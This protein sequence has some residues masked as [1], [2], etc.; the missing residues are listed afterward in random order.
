MRSNP[1]AFI[2]KLK[3][4]EERL[5]LLTELDKRYHEDNK[6]VVTDEQYDIMADYHYGST[7]RPVGSSSRTKA[8]VKLPVP[9]GSLTKFKVLPESSQQKFLKASVKFAV[10]DKED[11]IALQI[12][13]DGGVPVGAYTRGD[14]STGVDVTHIISHLKIPKKIARTERTSIRGELTCDKATFA[15]LFG[16][17][18]ATSRNFVGGLL[19]RKETSQALRKLKF[20]AY[21]IMDSGMGIIK[22]LLMLEKMKFDVVHWTILEN[23]TLVELEKL[24]NERKKNAPNDVDGI[25]VAQNVIYKNSASPTHAMAFKINSLETAHKVKVLRVVWEESRLGR[26]IPRIEIKPTIIGGVKVSFFTGHNYQYILDNDIGPG[27]TVLAVRSGDV[28]PYI[29]SVEKPTKAQLPEEAFTVKGVHAYAKKQKG[30]VKSDTRLIKELTYFFST[31]KVEGLKQGVVTQLVEAGYTTIKDFYSL[32]VADLLQLERFAERSAKQLVVALKKSRED[33]TFVKAAVGSGAFG[34][35]IGE[36]RLESII[37]AYPTI[38]TEDWSV[39]VLEGKIAALHGFKK[40][41]VDVA[42]NLENFRQFCRRNKIKLVAEKAVE[43]KGN[44]MVGQAALFTSVRDEELKNWILTQGGKIASTVKNAT[45]LLIKEGASNNKT[46]EAQKLGKQIYTI[47][48]FKAK[49]RI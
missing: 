42:Q 10:M 43:T 26:L 4:K 19:N 34:E 29:M 36:K 45:F 37:E 7:K 48:E 20:V 49:Y 38:M 5:A 3:T 21:E 13:Y 46:A 8:K 31:L 44:K 14:F 33:L 30:V 2:K 17:D 32:S 40:L 18:F 15:K 24:H 6:P 28:I 47:D 22:Q 9:M 11:G 41:A 35:G 27:T 25:V 23:P 12:V 1:L 16:K 39:D